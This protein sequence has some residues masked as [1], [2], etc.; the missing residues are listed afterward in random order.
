MWFLRKC[1]I[2]SATSTFRRHLDDASFHLIANRKEKSCLFFFSSAAR[3]S[4]RF[5]ACKTLH[6]TCINTIYSIISNL[7]SRFLSQKQGSCPKLLFFLFRKN[8]SH[9]RLGVK[10]DKRK[11]KK[12]TQGKDQRWRQITLSPSLIFV[13]PRT[14]FFPLLEKIHKPMIMKQPLQEAFFFGRGAWQSPARFS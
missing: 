3:N 12:K 4:C 9:D 1:F 10:K 6:I 5:F 7:Q 8:S 13:S 14:D 11:Q 2:S